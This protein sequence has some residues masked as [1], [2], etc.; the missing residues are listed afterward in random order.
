MW[1]EIFG[2]SFPLIS[3]Q[4]RSREGRE[5]MKEELI[6]QSRLQDI[7]NEFRRA[8]HV[9][10]SEQMTNASHTLTHSTPAQ[11]PLGVRTPHTSVRARIIWKGL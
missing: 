11:R 2:E 10:A 3:C 8:S 6:S 9:G 1:K 4:Q 5:S 7:K